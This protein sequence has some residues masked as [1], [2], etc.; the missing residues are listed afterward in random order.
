MPKHIRVTKDYNHTVRKG[1]IQSF[2]E[3]TIDLVPDNV[4][5]ALIAAGAAVE[6]TKA[7][8][9]AETKSEAQKFKG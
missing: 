3:G 8:A 1:F 9:K 5:E 2:K 7:E 4:A 6:T